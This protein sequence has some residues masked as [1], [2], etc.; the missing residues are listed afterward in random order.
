MSEVY[1]FY[2]VFFFI[3][4]GV[5]ITGSIYSWNGFR[6]FIIQIIFIFIF[7]LFTIYLSYSFVSGDPFALIMFIIYSVVHLFIF[8]ILKILYRGNGKSNRTSQ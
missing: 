2:T 5:S 7:L 3:F 8:F 1:I 4:F 6:F